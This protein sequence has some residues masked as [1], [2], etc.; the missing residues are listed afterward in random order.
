[1]GIHHGKLVN[2]GRL[3]VPVE[4]RRVLGFA[5]GERLVMEAV[6]D[7][8]RVRSYDAALKRV[9]E[10][11]KKYKPVGYNLSDELIADRRREAELE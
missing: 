4:L 5:D 1:M 3:I 2:G 11:M 10:R 6:G 8:L 7:E 9:Q